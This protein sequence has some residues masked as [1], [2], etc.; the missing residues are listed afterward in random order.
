L[1]ACINQQVLTVCQMAKVSKSM[2]CY[3]KGSAESPILQFCDR[4]EVMNDSGD[5]G[6]VPVFSSFSVSDFGNSSYC[7][8]F[9]RI[10]FM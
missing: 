9:L 5:G 8:T 4:P 1:S 7:R 10:Q 6:G 3:L 2:R